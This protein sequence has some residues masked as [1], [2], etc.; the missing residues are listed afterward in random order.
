MSIGDFPECLSQAMLVGIMLVGR[1]GVHARTRGFVQ[2]DAWQPAA[3]QADAQDQPHQ[4]RGARGGLPD[5]QTSKLSG[6]AAAKRV[7]RPTGA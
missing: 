3:D 6:S 4:R 7:L 5:C 1:L 2:R